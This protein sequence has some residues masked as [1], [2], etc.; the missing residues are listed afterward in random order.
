M[1]AVTITGEMYSITV[2]GPRAEIRIWR[3]PDL[4][5]ETGSKNAAAIAAESLKLAARGVRTVLLDVKDAPAVAGPKSIAS[6]SAMMA[7][8]AAAKMKIAILVSDDPIKML[9]F[10]RVVTEQAPRDACVFT[11]AAEAARWLASD[12]K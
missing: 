10:R 6:I 3:R 7:A 9:Q 2:D 12:G 8:W 1:A 5:T 11:D 4:D